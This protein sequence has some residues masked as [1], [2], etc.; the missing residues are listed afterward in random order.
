MSRKRLLGSIAVLFLLTIGVT[1]CGDTKTV[2]VLVLDS[3]PMLQALV[4][5]A[6]SE[7]A[8][9]AMMSRLRDIRTSCRCI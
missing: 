2:T 7:A 5:I 6:S 9:T 4:P 1:A 3:L 8:T